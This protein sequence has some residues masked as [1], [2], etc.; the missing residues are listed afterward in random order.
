MVV[1]ERTRAGG[2]AHF[3]QIGEFGMNFQDV[4]GQFG[5]RGNVAAWP[6]N[7]F[8]RDQL[9]DQHAVVR[10]LGDGQMEIAR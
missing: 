8:E 6:G 1:H 2:V 10:G 9:H 4:P 5:C 7:M 3:D